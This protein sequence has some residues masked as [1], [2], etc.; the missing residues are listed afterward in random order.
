VDRGGLARIEL[1][2]LADEV[3][4]RLL[5]LAGVLEELLELVEEDDDGAV[6]GLR[7]VLELIRQ[8]RVGE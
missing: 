8:R 7:D 5:V 4:C 2:D 6:E 1:R 3:E